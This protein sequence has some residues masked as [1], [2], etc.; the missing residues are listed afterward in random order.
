M[1]DEC[2]N[3][4]NDEEALDTEEMTDTIPDMETEELYFAEPIIFD[5]TSFFEENDEFK[6]GVQDASWFAGFY[7]TLISSGMSNK[8][9]FTCL[10]TKMEFDLTN[11]VSETNAKAT[12][13]SAKNAQISLEKTQI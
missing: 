9:A 10:F 13:E 1:C 11:K 2:K 8:E 4:I 5:D 12:I 6:K 7:A 3:I